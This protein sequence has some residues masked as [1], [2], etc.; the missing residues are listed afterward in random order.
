MNR[1]PESTDLLTIGEL[2][3]YL[4]GG[5]LYAKN[6]NSQ[7]LLLNKGVS[8]LQKF[9]ESALSLFENSLLKIAPTATGLTLTTALPFFYLG[10]IQGTAITAPETDEYLGFNETGELTH[11]AAP[12][13]RL[14][15]LSD[16]A[17]ERSAEAHNYALTFR[18]S[19]FP[20]TASDPYPTAIYGEWELQPEASRILEFNDVYKPAPAVAVPEP[21]HLY[22]LLKVIP[23]NPP[24]A[25]R[26]YL[27]Q[28]EVFEINLD[29]EPRL[30]GDLETEGCTI[31]NRFYKTQTWLVT[32]ATAS[33][34]LDIQRYSCFVLNCSG[35]VVGLNIDI[36][37]PPELEKLYLIELNLNNFVGFL[38]FPDT[39]RFENGQPPVLTGE[40]TV[41][42]L[43]VYT[44]VDGIRM[45]V[46]QKMNN[47][48]STQ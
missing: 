42:N 46:L 26:G 30:A 3:G 19:S 22:Y 17:L 21:Q 7:I 1:K 9:P 34:S 12:T 10:D 41:L 40:N 37:S 5:K 11:K 6:L 38:N 31:R 23:Q 32:E 43:M 29:Q 15:D 8:Q 33:I 13:F 39:M 28:R 24:T 36:Q 48:L 45:T 47:L 27:L 44:G 20:L 35:S 2:V 18:Y 16:V 4:P 25:L 14:E